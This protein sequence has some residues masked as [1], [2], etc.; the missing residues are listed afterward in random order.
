MRSSARRPC[1]YTMR[2]WI[3]MLLRSMPCRP[4]ACDVSETPRSMLMRAPSS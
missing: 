2:V 1:T 4:P 3:S